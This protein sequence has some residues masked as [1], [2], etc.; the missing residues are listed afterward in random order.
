MWTERHASP[1]VDLEVGE[2]GRRAEVAELSVLMLVCTAAKAK[3]VHRRLYDVRILPP[4]G[5]DHRMSTS[6]SSGRKVTTS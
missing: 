5:G 6:G 1:L 3:K 4:I 2:L